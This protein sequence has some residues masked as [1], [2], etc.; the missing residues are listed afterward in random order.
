[1]VQRVEARIEIVPPPLKKINLGG[2]DFS[3]KYVL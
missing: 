1:M 2:P 3:T